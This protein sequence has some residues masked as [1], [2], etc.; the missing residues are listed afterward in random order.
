MTNTINRYRYLKLTAIYA[1]FA[2][3]MALT[4][5][6]VTRGIQ[7]TPLAS[8]KLVLTA[9]K[10]AYAPGEEV[11]LLLSNDTDSVVY[12]QDHCPE[13]PLAISYKNGQTWE[14]IHIKTASKACANDKRHIAIQPHTSAPIHY[15]DWP[16]LFAR[17]GTYRIT[18]QLENYQTPLEEEIQIQ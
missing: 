14:E 13:P 2:I 8:D 16:Q 3:P 18:A 6:I 17:P 9:T 5:Y 15:D 4:G 1:I 10:D 11:K 7:A 12:V